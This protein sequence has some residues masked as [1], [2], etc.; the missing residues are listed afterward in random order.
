[1]YALIFSTKFSLISKAWQ[2]SSQSNPSP[3][4]NT[5]TSS[6]LINS[7]SPTENQ[8]KINREATNTTTNQ[9]RLNTENDYHVNGDDNDNDNDDD[10][11]DEE[12]EEVYDEAETDVQPAAASVSAL[13][14]PHARL[15]LGKQHHPSQFNQSS[16]SIGNDKFVDC[17]EEIVH[18][19]LSTYHDANESPVNETTL[20]QDDQEE[21]DTDLK[22][23]ERSSPLLLNNN[24]NC[25]STMAHHGGEDSLEIA[26]LISQFRHLRSAPDSSKD[27]EG[28]ANAT[29]NVK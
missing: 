9:T 2:Q 5:N 14:P 7:V 12:E 29:T 1:M 6:N 15:L 11:D 22:R 21:E 10:D 3:L 26:E 8:I 27:K 25:K 28:L 24:A 20:N 13:L 16:S 17:C 19:D 18:A 23:F 4:L